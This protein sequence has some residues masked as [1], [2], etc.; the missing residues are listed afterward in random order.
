MQKSRAAIPKLDLFEQ[1][2]YKA[3]LLALIATYPSKGR[4][5]HRSMAEAIRCQ[6]A[7]IS[8]VLAGDYHFSIEQ[9]EA[10]ARFFGLS[11]AESEFFVLLVSHNRSGTTELRELG[12]SAARLAWNPG[13][14]P[15]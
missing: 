15:L 2:D 1:T 11:R 5:I 3:Y 10:S 9:A 4:G 12:G 13:A 6:V 14:L 8:H 7:Y